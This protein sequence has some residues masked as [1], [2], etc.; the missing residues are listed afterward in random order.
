MCCCQV[1]P[2]WSWVLQ[3]NRGKRRSR[4]WNNFNRIPG[5]YMKEVGRMRGG[6]SRLEAYRLF[7]LPNMSEIWS[8]MYPSRVRL[9]YQ[10]HKLDIYFLR[11]SYIANRLI[12]PMELSQPDPLVLWILETVNQPRHFN[13]LS[14]P[15]RE[16]WNIVNLSKQLARAPPNLY[17]I[18][19]PDLSPES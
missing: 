12:V 16:S 17:R 9:C 7:P 13:F 10:L 2:D 6:C 19:R 15:N 5:D 14:I 4:T 8:L 11:Y 3:G 1:G 18:S